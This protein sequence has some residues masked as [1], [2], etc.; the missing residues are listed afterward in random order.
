MPTPGSAP[1]A[2]TVSARDHLARRR[3]VPAAVPGAA[4]GVPFALPLDEETRRR[5]E[6]NPLRVLDDKRPRPGDDRRRAADARP[7]LRHGKAHFDELLAHLDA[8]GVPYVVT[9]DGARAGLLHQDHV[10]VRPRRPGRPVGD[11]WRRPLRRADGDRRPALSGIGFGLGVDRT[12]LALRPR[13]RPAAAGGVEVFGVPLGD[14]AKAQLVCSRH[15]CGA[16]GFAATSRT[17]RGS[18]VP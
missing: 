5:A 9:A 14:E 12:V 4:A 17:A 7:P 6:I 11:R 2:S 10:R 8:L 18:R 16:R 15:S 13:A 3:H 1:S